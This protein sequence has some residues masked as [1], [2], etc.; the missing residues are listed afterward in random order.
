MLVSLEVGFQVIFDKSFVDLNGFRIMG[1]QR[2][3]P[4]SP[5]QMDLPHR[6]VRLQAEEIISA[7]ENAHESGTTPTHD[8][9]DSRVVSWSSGAAVVV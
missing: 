9:P 8:F 6:S 4:V 2:G 1:Q 3:Q 7:P 5:L